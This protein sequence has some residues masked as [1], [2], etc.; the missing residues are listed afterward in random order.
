MQPYTK[1]PTVKKQIFFLPN[2]HIPKGIRGEG[3]R[4]QRGGGHRG[5]RRRR[6]KQESRNTQAH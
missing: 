5:G 1:K 2:E 4:G 3:E 6:K